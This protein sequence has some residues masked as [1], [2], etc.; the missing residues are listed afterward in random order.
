ML[1]EVTDLQPALRYSPRSYVAKD[2]VDFARSDMAVAELVVEGKTWR[3]TYTAARGWVRRHPGLCPGV[4][5]TRRGERVFLVKE[6]G[7]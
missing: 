7:Q 6:V 4:G 2:I 3:Q 1:R 5:V